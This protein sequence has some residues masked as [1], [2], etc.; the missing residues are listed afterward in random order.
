MAGDALLCVGQKAFIEK[1]GKVLILSDPT[2]GLDFPGGKI[3]VGEAKSDDALSLSRSLRREVREETGLEIEVGDPFVV[4]YHEFPRNHRNYPKAVYLVGF[5]CKYVSGEVRLSDE[6]N[7]FK[8]L[9]KSD[10]ALFDGRNGYSSALRKYF[11][12]SQVSEP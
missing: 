11:D 12:K 8:W 9:D 1:D 2:E 4:W 3:Q 6:H 10:R 7:K 5:R